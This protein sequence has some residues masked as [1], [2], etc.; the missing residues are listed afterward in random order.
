MRNKKITAA[1]FLCFALICSFIAGKSYSAMH[2]EE[3][4]VKGPG[5]SEQKMLSDYFPKLKG[6][7][8]GD[9]EVYIFHGG[10]TRWKYVGTRWNSSQ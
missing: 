4:I 1:I 7:N 2:V 10:R 9:T 6:T 8:G 5:V 3:P